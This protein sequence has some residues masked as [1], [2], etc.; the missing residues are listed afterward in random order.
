MGS[1]GLLILMRFDDVFEA[2][3][4]GIVVVVVVG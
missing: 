1:W 2:S 4:N 3:E